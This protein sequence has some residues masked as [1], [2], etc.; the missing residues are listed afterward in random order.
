MY[1]K[2][3]EYRKGTTMTEYVIVITAIVSLGSLPMG[4]WHAGNQHGQGL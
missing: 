2:G 1:V 3:R 4:P